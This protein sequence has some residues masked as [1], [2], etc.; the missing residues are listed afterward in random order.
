MGLIYKWT[1]TTNGKAY[2]GKCHNTLEKRTREHLAGRGSQLLKSAFDKYGVDAFTLE[3]LYDGVFDVMLDTFE[4]DAIKTYNTKAPNG[5]NLT[6]GGTGGNGLKHTEE[7]KKKVSERHKG[8]VMSDEQKRKISDAHKGK[9]LTEEHKAKLSLA[10][11]GKVSS[12][13]HRL[14]QSRAIKAWWTKR[15]G[16]TNE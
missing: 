3:I 2:I 4:R 1:N 12:K 7:F 11:K 10:H 8:K 9:T 16:E 6:D 13:E 5:Y 15:K 14:N